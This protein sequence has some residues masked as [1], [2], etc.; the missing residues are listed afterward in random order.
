MTHR[1][2]SSID[3]ILD[4]IP[5]KNLSSFMPTVFWCNTEVELDREK[6]AL[7]YHPLLSIQKESTK[8]DRQRMLRS[9]LKLAEDSDESSGDQIYEFAKRWGVLGICRHNKP[10]GI[11]SKVRDENG[12]P[13]ACIPDQD[14]EGRHYDRL[15]GWRLYAKKVNLIIRIGVALR[16]NRYELRASDFVPLQGE[17]SYQA[18]PKNEAAAKLFISNVINEWTIMFQIFPRMRWFGN[19]EPR[20]EF[21]PVRESVASSVFPQIVL[22]LLFAVGRYSGV[23]ECS[24][25]NCENIFFL[26][27]Q[28]SKSKGHYCERCQRVG[29]AGLAARK[30]SYAKRKVGL[31]MNPKQKIPDEYIERIYRELKRARDKGV[32]MR[33]VVQKYAKQFGVDDS[34]VYRLLNEKYIAKRRETIKTK[35][36][37][38][39]K[40]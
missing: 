21:T 11:C 38:E 23:V 39:K 35:R 17:F 7:Y 15:D 10:Y 32:S 25:P 20:I 1:A 4:Q 26:S 12:R 31:P 24:N 13:V 2:T 19:Q 16:E 30:R 33:H 18:I 40:K 22:E 14:D 29:E 37:P 27:P 36:N 28:Q 8:D 9:F 6:Q 34:Q 3:S 5:P